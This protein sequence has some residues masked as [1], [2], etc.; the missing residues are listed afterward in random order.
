M[1]RRK[2]M[3]TLGYAPYDL[4]LERA[5][6]E[7]LRNHLEYYFLLYSTLDARRGEGH[8]AAWRAVAESAGVLCP[9]VDALVDGFSF[10][11]IPMPFATARVLPFS[12]L[13]SDCATVFAGAKDAD[14]DAREAYDLVCRGLRQLRP[15]F[16]RLPPPVI[17]QRPLMPRPGD[18]DFPGGPGEAA[19]ARDG[20]PP[21]PLEQLMGV[22][23]KR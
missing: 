15:V 16:A 19:A 21:T 22:R 13:L 5:T 17:R 20:P 8:A 10:G 14:P 2:E 1:F 11:T 23:H 3:A 18:E 4:A 7:A 6:V 9:I 12:G